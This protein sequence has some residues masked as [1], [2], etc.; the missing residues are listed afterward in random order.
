MAEFPRLALL[1]IETSQSDKLRQLTAR[2]I[3]SEFISSPD[4]VQ[5]MLTKLTSV[6]DDIRLDIL[7]G[8]AE[9][10]R[11]WQ[12]VTPPKNWQAVVDVVEK[13]DNELAKKRVRELSI[14]FGDGRAAADLKKIAL[15]DK[16]DPTTR[17][18]ALNTLLE[19]SPDSITPDD[20]YRLLNDKAIRATAA[21]GLAKYNDKKT[22][23]ILIG[24]FHG[25]DRDGQN[26]IIDTLAS[27][28]DYATRLVSEIDKR[29]P[30][31]AISAY[32]A[33]QMLQFN[34]PT[35]EKM[36]NEKWGQIRK[37]NEEKQA[38]LAKYKKLLT[39]EYLKLAD[40]A[41]GKQL[42]TQI[43]SACHKMNG[44]GGVIGP[45]LTGSNRDNLDYLLGNIIDPSAVMPEDFRASAVL[46]KDGRVI[47][48][49]IKSQDA[50][51]VKIQTMTTLEIL[52]T[53]HIQEKQLLKVSLMPEGMLEVFTN[54]QVRDLIGYL[55]KK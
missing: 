43:C 26:A 44:A 13:S 30:R 6:N 38:Q 22:P 28:L 49:F 48:G 31:A 7:N 41:K 16:N 21:R 45:D 10:S 9:A 37:S 51:T 1:L 19:Q 50:R 33:R 53:D 11:G 14:V 29:I 12:K 17:T 15:S 55:M 20:L 4:I 2:R 47:M 36:L 25:M 35:L 23:G 18:S 24:K 27:R 42:Y 40:I 52:Q 39:P 8:M 5:P 54:E 3:M 46:L 32:H 34:D